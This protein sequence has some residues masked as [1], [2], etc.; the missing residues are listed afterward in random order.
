MGHYRRTTRAI[1][2]QI[3]LLVV[4][5]SAL[6]E[7]TE[8]KRPVLPGLKSLCIPLPSEQLCSFNQDFV[9]VSTLQFLTGKSV[10]DAAKPSNQPY[11][12]ACSALA[13]MEM[14]VSWTPMQN[15]TLNIR[16]G[17]ID[18]FT[19]IVPGTERD[20]NRYVPELLKST[21]QTSQYLCPSNV[22]G[23]DILS[24]V[25]QERLE[26][27]SAARNGVDVSS[28]QN[29]VLRPLWVFCNGTSVD[30]P[31]NRDHGNGKGIQARGSD[32]MRN[33]VEENAECSDDSTASAVGWNM[34]FAQSDY[35]KTI[36]KL[37]LTGYAEGI[38]AKQSQTT[39]L[40]RQR[41]RRNSRY[42]FSYEVPVANTV[43]QNDLV[44]LQLAELRA[45]RP[46]LA[47]LSTTRAQLSS[48]E[49]QGTV[50]QL[51][52][53]SDSI[54]PP[55][56]FGKC[57]SQIRYY[58]QPNSTANQPGPDGINIQIPNG[59][60]F[61]RRV[62]DIG[63][64][65][66]VQTP[67]FNFEGDMTQRSDANFLEN[68]QHGTDWEPDQTVFETSFMAPDYRQLSLLPRQVTDQRSICNNQS[69]AVSIP[70]Y[71]RLFGVS[72]LRVVTQNA[73]N[74]M[75]ILGRARDPDT[76]G[77]RV[78]WLDPPGRTGLV[79]PE[80]VPMQSFQR[81]TGSVVKQT[82]CFTNT[83]GKLQLDDPPPMTP[84]V[85]NR[86]SVCHENSQVIMLGQQIFQGKDSPD[87]HAQCE[88][89]QENCPEDYSP[90]KYS[91][92]A[93]NKTAD[94]SCYSW[95]TSLGNLGTFEITNKTRIENY[96]NS[97]LVVNASVWKTRTQEPLNVF[98]VYRFRPWS[99][100]S[101]AYIGWGDGVLCGQ[102]QN[103]MFAAAACYNTCY[104]NWTEAKSKGT[105]Y[106]C[107]Q[108]VWHFSGPGG[109]PGKVKYANGS[110]CPMFF[111]RYEVNTI[112]W[113]PPRKHTHVTWPTLSPRPP[114]EY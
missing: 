55:S 54:C 10:G 4:I 62:R 14:M 28:P 7:P 43:T 77:Q 92:L 96:L 57:V 47:Q 64:N 74:K 33:L 16:E 11:F 107:D 85:A 90:G 78:G 76:S 88:L 3:L 93:S 75:C 17:P 29:G 73:R 41:Y 84:S 110:H 53:Y 69:F 30:S 22:D 12:D 24:A 109:E 36:I 111:E 42:R 61:E 81:K 70:F 91:L 67:L 37:G 105:K 80:E 60:F 8:C 87:S 15:G 38:Q 103:M 83:T 99:K 112:N 27:I 39:C 113:V 51:V 31:F 40:A 45:G 114:T 48:L 65:S 25:V 13:G 1:T 98:D 18:G 56:E 6:A 19:V 97:E 23:R 44:S 35:F 46:P 71:N 58:C 108:E 26:A 20:C 89:T 86:S 59:C 32:S 101:G 95:F 21:A 50:R 5:S 106:T 100:M 104:Q 52:L 63:A 72:N 66:S 34:W 82:S 68:S 79:L 102:E 2:P 49:A 94:R 9:V